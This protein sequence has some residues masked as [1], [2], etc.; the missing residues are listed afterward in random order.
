MTNEN[1]YS[2][3][4]AA[5]ADRP[6]APRS[7]VVAVIVGL[8][9]D[10]GGS[11][12]AGMMLSIAYGI[13]LARSGVRPDEIGKALSSI[14]PWTL[15]WAV[16]MTVGVAFSVLGGFVCARIARRRSYRP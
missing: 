5:L 3:P 2:A 7:A 16:S 6:G 1:P 12:V 8:V 4:E 13:S 15:F 11:L 10:V 14:Q 9:T